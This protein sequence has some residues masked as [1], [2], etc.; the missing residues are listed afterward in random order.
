MTPVVKEPVCQCRRWKRHRFDACVRKI[1]WR[2]ASQP[3]PIFLPGKIPWTE[4]PGR[5]QSMESQR[6]GHDWACMHAF[7]HKQTFSLHPSP[8]E[9][10]ICIPLVFQMVA[11]L[12]HRKCYFLGILMSHESEQRTENDKHWSS[13]PAFEFVLSW[14]LVQGAGQREERIV[15]PILFLSFTHFPQ[16]TNEQTYNHHLTLLC[17]HRASDKKCEF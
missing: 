4:G 8:R 15:S 14:S 12:H 6:V 16:V 13:L 9:F 5:L 3:T 7:N 17:Q 1:S 11:L 10:Y 2:R